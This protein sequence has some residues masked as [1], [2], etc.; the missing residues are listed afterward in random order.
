MWRQ[1]VLIEK[2]R[3]A[4]KLAQTGYQDHLESAYR[5]SFKTRAITPFRMRCLMGR[6]PLRTARTGQQKQDDG[7]G[8]PYRP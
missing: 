5:I 1:E 3:V 6:I 2:G 7:N 8:Q 4:L